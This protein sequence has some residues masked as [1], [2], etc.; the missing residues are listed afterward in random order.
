MNCYG[1]D[2]YNVKMEKQALIKKGAYL[3]NSKCCDEDCGVL[4]KDVETAADECHSL[5]R[6]M[7]QWDDLD[8]DGKILADSLCSELE[9]K[10]IN[11]QG[12]VSNK[13]EGIKKSKSKSKSRIRSRR[14]KSR[15]RKSRSRRSKS[16][17]SSY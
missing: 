6:D 3:L 12:V 4:I 16:R 9:E 14:R 15:R 17:K 2:P 1:K 7:H 13:A 10:K 8:L 11:L 5:F